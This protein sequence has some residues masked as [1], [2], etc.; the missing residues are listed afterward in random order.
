MKQVRFEISDEQDDRLNE[1]VASYG[2]KDK[3]DLVNTAITL[4]EW[5]IKQVRKGRAIACVDEERGKYKTLTMPIFD[6]CK[7][8]SIS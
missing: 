4:L 6:R 5:S 3:R 8:D 2:C 7:K 1:M